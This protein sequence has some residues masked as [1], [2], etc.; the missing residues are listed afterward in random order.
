MKVLCIYDKSGPKY[1]RILMPVFLMPGAEIV[2]NYKLEEKQLTGIDIV[3]FNRLIPGI[4]IQKVLELRERYGFKLIVDFDDHWV[5][6][7]DHVLYEGYRQHRISEVMEA[8]IKEA[9]AVT[10]THERLYKQVI[11]INENCHIL[12]NAIPRYDQFLYKK[13]S[14]E[15]VRLFWAG[16][17][18]HKKDLELLK[19]P[20]QLI[21]RDKVKFVLGGYVKGEPEWDAMARVFTGNSSYNTEVIESLPVDKYYAMYAK[22]D[23]G[24]IPLLDTEFNSYKSNLKI[25]E[26]ANIAAP[27]VVSRVDPYLNFPEHIVNY[28]DLHNTWYSQI[29]Y[30]IE[31][32][33]FIKEQGQM[34]KEFCDVNYN[35]V[36]INEYRKQLFYATIQQ[37]ETRIPSARTESAGG[38]STGG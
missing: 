5:L 38:V 19:R 10:V 28:V 18:T 26:A 12:P 3:F 24:L 35:F 25:L 2:T 31:N 22:C 13:I 34:L 15:K 9:D 33:N 27:V 1:H 17:I 32:P 16:G 8:Y 29:R 7:K 4:T 37:G 21:R 23:I 6:G 11:H 30:L 36:K 14:D 20:L